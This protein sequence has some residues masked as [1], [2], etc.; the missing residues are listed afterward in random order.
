L[1]PKLKKIVKPVPA[2]EPITYNLSR[3]GPGLRNR[4]DEDNTD[5]V[6]N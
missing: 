3:F 4:K 1:R 6:E 2:Q 5:D